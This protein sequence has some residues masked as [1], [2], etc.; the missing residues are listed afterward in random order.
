MEELSGEIHLSDRVVDVGEAG[1][2][3]LHATGIFGDREI[4][5][6]EIPVLPIQ[7]HVSGGTIGKEVVPDAPPKI[8]GG[9]GTHDVIDE[10][11]GQSGV[12][13]KNEVSIEFA[14]VGIGV[15]WEGLFNELGDAI[16]EKNEEEE[17]LPLVVVVIVGVEL[18][19]D[20]VL[21]AVMEDRVA[22]LGNGGWRGWWCSGL[23]N[24]G[25][26]ERCKRRWG[27][28]CTENKGGRG[29]GGGRAGGRVVST[30]VVEEEEV[31]PEPVAGAEGRSEVVIGGGWCLIPSKR[32][33]SFTLDQHVQWCYIY[34]AEVEESRSRSYIQGRLRLSV[35]TR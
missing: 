10:G 18:E 19:F 30:T 27:R 23:R 6:F 26:E 29:G 13:P 9:G 15:G 2:E 17:G 33:Y 28:G 31:W 25:G 7:G 22:G 21:D 14:E 34:I 3:E 1:G 20:M 8:E 32:L 35:M 12:D 11:I 24:G 16:A 5:L 4:T